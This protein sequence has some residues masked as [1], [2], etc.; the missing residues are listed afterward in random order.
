MADDTGSPGGRYGP[1]IRSARG[2]MDK[3]GTMVDAADKAAVTPSSRPDFSS[4]EYDPSRSFA[5]NALNPAGIQKAMD[6]G[7]MA[8]G[9]GASNR[10]RQAGLTE[11][12]GKAEGAAGVRN[13]DVG[14]MSAKEAL[15]AKIKRVAGL[16]MD[17]ALEDSYD[18]AGVGEGFFR[19][20]MGKPNRS[21]PL[22]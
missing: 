18:K 10:F 20:V 11:S 22:K 14:G 19:R 2:D 3:L 16:E 17:R 7:M 12:A 1:L 6:V 8:G 4:G 21:I 15:G 5:A 13:S 9:I